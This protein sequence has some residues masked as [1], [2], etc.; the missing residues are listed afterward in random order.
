LTLNIG[1][2]STLLMAEVLPADATYGVPVW[3][4]ENEEIVRVDPVT[5][6]VTGVAPGRAVIR[7]TAGEES[8]T[9]TVTVADLVLKKATSDSTDTLTGETITMNVGDRITV[10]ADV[11]PGNAAK[12]T[13][14]ITSGDVDKVI[15][16]S[17][18][19]PAAPWSDQAWTIIADKPTSGPLTMTAGGDGLPGKIFYVEVIRPVTSITIKDI[20]IDGDVCFGEFTFKCPM[21]ADVETA[22]ATNKDL[23]WSI[24]T[25]GTTTT[26]DPDTGEVTGTG[27]GK[28]TIKATATDGS[29][30]FDTREVTIYE[31]YVITDPATW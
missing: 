4:T 11:R 6:R 2:T 12:G 27:M 9:C 7:A 8:D 13:V 24:D 22:N 16:Q 29:G 5:G 30:V 10:Y 20:S 19:A 23:L 17:G 14:L 15:T 25:P 1:E 26:V 3:S 18:S 21:K 28:V 31:A